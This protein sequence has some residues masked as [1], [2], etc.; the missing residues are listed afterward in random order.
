MAIFNSKLLVYQRVTGNN[1]KQ[2][3]FGSP[4]RSDQG[5]FHI[6]TRFYHDR[7]CRKG[8][9]CCF[10]CVKIRVFQGFNTSL[11]VV[12]STGMIQETIDS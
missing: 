5:H 8:I 9:F 4:K 11:F 12:E 7:C 2:L 1:D 3:D 10:N 6:H